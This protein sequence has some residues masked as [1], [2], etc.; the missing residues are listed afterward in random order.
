[1]DMKLDNES[2]IDLYTKLIKNEFEGQDERY[3]EALVRYGECILNTDSFHFV[4]P[5]LSQKTILGYVNLAKLS[6]D[7]L[8]EEVIEEHVDM[9]L[10]LCRLVA[11]IFS[12]IDK[13][14]CVDLY[15]DSVICL[16]ELGKGL[17]ARRICSLLN[18]STTPQ[19]AFYHPT[20]VNNIIPSDDKVN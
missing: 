14:N 1:M 5:V 2:K 18:G 13:P 3:I 8:T 6:Y 11:K 9:D 4:D 16:V 7:S 15:M 20:K 12:F 19:A 10:E 17:V